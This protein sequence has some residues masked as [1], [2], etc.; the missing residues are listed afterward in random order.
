MPFH[1]APRHAERRRKQV[2]NSGMPQLYPAK[3]SHE[4][5]TAARL[6]WI[7]LHLTEVV[8]GRAR[9]YVGITTGT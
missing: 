4:V 2:V 8:L 5:S 6:T 7:N 9:S 1:F 3:V